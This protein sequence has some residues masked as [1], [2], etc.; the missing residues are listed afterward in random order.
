MRRAGDQLPP[1]RRAAAF[2]TNDGGE[3]FDK[4]EDPTKA[5]MSSAATLDA[6]QWLADAVVRHKVAPGEGGAA[7]P[8]FTSGRVAMVAQGTANIGRA[9]ADIKGQFPWDIAVHP[10]GKSG[11]P[12]YAGTLFGGIAAATKLPD[13]AWTFLK[14][15]CGAQG[16]RPFVEAQVGAP[17]LR[18][19]EKVYAALPPPPENRKAVN[20]TLPQLRALPKSVR[21]NDMYSSIFGKLLGDAFAGK[22]AATDAARQIDEQASALL[23]S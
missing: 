6:L 2:E 10:K 7:V 12:N 23:R 19:L 8:N 13:A 17:A 18:E 14:Y 15:F 11:R 1:Q 5:T 21:M 22:I 4:S 9:A 20:E 16:A 3:A